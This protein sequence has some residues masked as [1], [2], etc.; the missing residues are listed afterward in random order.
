MKLYADILS[1]LKD[2]SRYSLANIAKMVGSDE[3]TVENA[4]LDM[5]KKVFLSNIPPLLTE[6]KLIII[7][8]KLL[9]KCV[10]HPKKIWA[11]MPLQKILPLVLR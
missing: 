10:L 9:L 5:E 4:I 8:W 7:W 11:L 1:V 6:Q 2:D 3:K